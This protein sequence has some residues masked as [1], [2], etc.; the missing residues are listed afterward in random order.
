MYSDYQPIVYNA[1]Q[2]Q[3]EL[4]LYFLHDVHLGSSEHS[5]AKLNAFLQIVQE[6][7]MA[8]VLVI[9]DMCEN[10]VPGSKGDIFYQIYSPHE[11]KYRTKEIFADLH[12]AGKLLAV[13]P[14]NHERNRITRT[15]SMFPLYDACVMA[16]CE[17][18]YRQHFAFVDIGLGYR[19]RKSSAGRGA[20]QRYVGFITH[21]AKDQVNFHSADTIEGIDFFAFGHDHNPKD[22]PRGKLKYYPQLQTVQ[23][24]TVEVINCGSFLDY[25]G[26][27]VDSGYRVP[28][29]KMYMLI[30]RDQDRGIETR[31][32][33]V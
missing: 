19:K 15:T 27:P 17:S 22:K 2:E 9:G 8:R 4:H 3:S 21:R 30:L 12:K 24:R 33:Y 11:Q 18:A 25:N 5:T 29:Q 6:D 31:G 23:Q 26:Y 20:Q 1:P 10:V 13:V 28:A 32:F 7:L 16:G 14:G